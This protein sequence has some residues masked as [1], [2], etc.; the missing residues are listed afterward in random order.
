MAST[1]SYG[2]LD[3]LWPS[4]AKYDRPAES[5]VP[6][7]RPVSATSMSK[8]STSRNLKR[9]R[10]YSNPILDRSPPSE[11]PTDNPPVTDQKHRGRSVST[12]ATA[13]QSLLPDGEGSIQTVPVATFQGSLPK[14][15]LDQSL[16]KSPNIDHLTN[17]DR[18]TSNKSM[19]TATLRNAIESQFNLEIL[20]KHR[21]LRLIDQE[22]AKCHVALEQ[23]RRCQIIPY[24]QS[25]PIRHTFEVINDSERPPSSER[26]SSATQWSV[27]NAAYS[28]HYE[29]WLLG[30]S[31]HDNG[32][33]HQDFISAKNGKRLPDRLTR[34]VHPEK[35]FYGT[36]NRS[37]RGSAKVPMETPSPGHSEA[38]DMKGPMVVPRKSDNHLVKLVCLDCHRSNFNSVQGFINHCRIAHSRQFAS[39]EAAIE[40][41][42]EGIDRESEESAIADAHNEQAAASV[43]LVHPMIK[44]ARPSP[45]DDML[46]STPSDI[47][48]TTPRTGPLLNALKSTPSRSAL[49]SRN[50]QSE[51]FRASPRT[52]HLSALF[53]R[54]GQSGD[55]DAMVL[56]ARNREETNLLETFMNDSSDESENEVAQDAT[57]RGV[58]QCGVRPVSSASSRAKSEVK[59]SG[60]LSNT[61]SGHSRTPAT[62]Q[63]VGGASN[64][65]DVPQ[66]SS[67]PFNLSPN[68]T[69]PHPAPSLV[70]DDDDYDNT[71]SESEYSSQMDLD[72]HDQFIH[73]G[74]VDDEELDLGEADRLSFTQPGKHHGAHLERRSRSPPMGRGS[75]YAKRR[76]T[77]ASPARSRSGS[78]RVPSD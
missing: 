19:S 56:D 18:P 70:S 44:S 7:S 60:G 78:R 16:S 33:N 17:V 10:G 57:S 4:S 29:K 42:G 53:S 50:P 22:L 65:D 38:K 34:G 8:G 67:S 35:G 74:I 46:P 30:Y 64:L 75:A 43:G 49:Q 40:A 15:S 37:Q 14:S 62:V 12:V 45:P 41:S 68:S 47:Y 5:R 2:M 6:A 76:V 77:F 23:L 59:V 1:A 69:D 28:M 32:D 3:F 51:V 52:P 55:L 48:S 21:E 27:A 66:G 20:L 73:A 31:T 72:E 9:K 58:S 26:P 36:S 39:H 71:H 11:V 13:P 63:S 54:M 24:P 25:S 61:P